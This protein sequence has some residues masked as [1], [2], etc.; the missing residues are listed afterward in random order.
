MQ[1]SISIAPAA[2]ISRLLAA[3]CLAVFAIVGAAQSLPAKFD[4]ARDAVADVAAATAQ[5]KAQGKRVLVDVGGEWC[6]WCHILDRFVAANDDVR[7]LRDANYVWVKV[8]WSKENKNQAL[9]SRWPKI[10][11]YPH[12]FVLD[13]T[14]KLLHSQDTGAL[15]SGKDYDHA[16]LTA[17]L[18]SWA[19]AGKGA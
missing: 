11:G 16:K 19:P 8:N 14:G 17:F 15:E 18:K 12:L 7:A 1:N 9:L 3:L 6:S 13:G 4:P 2:S 10:N 5:A